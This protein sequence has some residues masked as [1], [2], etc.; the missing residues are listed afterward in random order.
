M[1]VETAP[2]SW[3][4]LS[5]SLSRTLTVRGRSFSTTWSRSTRS[6]FVVWLVTRTL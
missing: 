2:S 3:L 5:M 4:R 6:A 1:M